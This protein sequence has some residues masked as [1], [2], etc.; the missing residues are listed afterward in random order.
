MSTASRLACLLVPLFPLASRLRSEP[1]LAGEAVVIVEGNGTAAHIISASRKSR[2]AGITAGM[3]VPQA[4]ALLPKLVARGRDAA[5]EKAAQEVLIEI[6]GRFSPRWE[7]A[8]PGVVYLDLGKV[9]S[10][11]ST[12]EAPLSV[13]LSQEKSLGQD[14]ILAAAHEK[15]PARCGIASSKLAARVAAGLAE[16]PAVVPDGEESAFLA[17]LPLTRLSPA[18]EVSA[19]LSRWGVASIGDFA[20]LPAA[21]VAGKLGE[22]GR[23]L[24]EM[25]RGLDP[26][27][28]FPTA[29]AP[30][31][32]E[33]F[34]LDWPLVT[35]EPFL[36][37]A[38]GALE[39][40]MQRLCAEALSCRELTLELR[41]DPAGNDI[42]TLSLPAP[43]REIKTLKSLVRIDMEA[44]PP[45]AAVAGFTFTAHPDRPRLGQLSLFGPMEIS[46]GQ[47]ATALARLAVLVGEG[48]SGSPQA[49]D[50][51]RPERVAIA[52]YL[53]P[54]PPLRRQPAQSH[55]LL[56]I[57]VLRPAVEL[58]V[59]TREEP[60]GTRPVS[61]KVCPASGE[62]AAGILQGQILVASG[63][64]ALEDNWWTDQPAV[65]QYWDVELSGGVLCRLFQ[66]E[67][68]GNWYADGIYD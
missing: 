19:T 40:L 9:P 38:E 39:R 29:P 20:R 63:P 42:R 26:Q 54:P 48:R 57:R 5:S 8:E 60:Q 59:L 35:L 55:G 1:G 11:V 64:W 17:P 23:I 3:T 14:M 12:V 10:R 43:T 4:R 18:L 15:L 6:A 47:L 24:H 51:H 25:A 50:G 66:D 30:S 41:L 46:P 65:R 13:S 58:E 67:T 22:P 53:P 62:K 28:L 56:A 34:D 33:G 49:V 44:R 36:N 31:F 37:L 68:N 32:S 61:M 45:G 21:E 16:S 52:P 27:P 2:M 7:D